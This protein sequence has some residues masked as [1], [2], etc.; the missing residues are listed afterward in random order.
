MIQNKAEGD[1]T[2]AAVDLAVVGKLIVP[3]ESLGS[4]VKNCPRPLSPAEAE[5][6]RRPNSFRLPTPNLAFR[7][8]SHANRFQA[9]QNQPVVVTLAEKL[10]RASVHFV[11]NTIVGA[12]SHVGILEG[13]LTFGAHG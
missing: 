5:Q 3:A 12:C 9:A 4:Q 7:R 13:M 1:W 6:L 10:V 8:E 11:G 2:D